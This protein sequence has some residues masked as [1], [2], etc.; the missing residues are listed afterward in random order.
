MRTGAID[1]AAHQVLAKA[2]DSGGL[3]ARG[4]H[5]VLRVA[6]TIADLELRQ[7]VRA[8]DVLLALNL[9]Q[10]TDTEQARAA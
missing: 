2:Y 6:R 7:S 3:S 10:R 5:R 8:S 1:E 9:R 4:R